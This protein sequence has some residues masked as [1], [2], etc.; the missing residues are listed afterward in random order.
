[1][2]GCSHSIEPLFSIVY[3]RNV[4]DSLGTNLIEVNALFEQVAKEKGF[5]SESLIKKILKHGGLKNLKEI[6][7][8]IKELFVTAHD[9][10]P[11]WH[12]RMQAAFQ[13]YTD[14]AVSK[15]VNLPNSATIEDVK[16]IFLLA[17]DLGC[18]GITVY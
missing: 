11:E 14:N 1:I 17:Y 4:K 13:K 10:S 5:Y 7:D 16:K 15:T 12:V 2:A 8:E 9:I 6:P 3:V 18:K